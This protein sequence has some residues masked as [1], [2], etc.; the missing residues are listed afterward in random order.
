M[1]VSRPLTLA[2]PETEPAQVPIQVL[3]RPDWRH[4]LHRLEQKRL[5]L[6]KTMASFAAI[7]PDFRESLELYDHACLAFEFWASQ[8]GQSAR[9]LQSDY[10]TI[11]QEMAEDIFMQFC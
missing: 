5:D 10:A 2:S 7:C 8:Q 4:G 1:S 3:V 6:H 9:A 11:R